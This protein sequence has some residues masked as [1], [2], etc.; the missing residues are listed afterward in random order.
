MSFL[1]I[2]QLTRY[3]S[4]AASTRQRFEQ[5]APFLSDAGFKTESWPLFDDDYLK[6]LYDGKNKGPLYTLKSYWRR[7]A[8][9]ATRRDIDLVWVHYELFPYLPGFLERSITLL[10][11]PIVYDFDDAIFHN[12]DQNGCSILRGI[13]GNKLAPLISRADVALCGNAYLADYAR[14]YCNNAQIVPT[15]LDTSVFVPSSKCSYS[16]DR[17]LRIGWLGTPSTWDAYV[18]PL[19]PMLLEEAGRVNGE[20]LAVGSGRSGGTHEHLVRRDWSEDREVADINDMDVC[21]MPLDESPWAHGKCGYKLIQYMAC[22]RPVIASPIGVNASIVDHHENGFLA[23]SI[24][25]WRTA[26]RTLL[27]DMPMRNR[28]GNAGREKAVKE[29]SLSTWGPRVASIMQDV[30]KR[31]R[32]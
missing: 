21:I 25:D 13:L 11:A 27:S 23:T 12:Y 17:P 3:G 18:V 32:V 6:Q 29:Y 5:Y 30:S 4:L 20:V 19:L 15:V 31:P 8:Q 2:A 14:Q 1:R 10:G 22:G 28:F 24:E 16:S 7:I 26:L 9:L